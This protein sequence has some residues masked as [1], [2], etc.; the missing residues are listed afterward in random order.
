[1]TDKHN[2]EI[3]YLKS[4]IDMRETELSSIQ[5]YVSQRFREI[6]MEIVNLSCIYNYVDAREREY[7]IRAIL[8]GH[9]MQLKMV[10]KLFELLKEEGLYDAFMSILQR[11]EGNTDG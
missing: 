2:F 5:H 8:A 11:E 10:E 1:M 9:R 7:R 4:L 6:P 3:D